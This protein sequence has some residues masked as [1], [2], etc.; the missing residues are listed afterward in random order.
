VRFYDR[1]SYGAAVEVVEAALRVVSAA[2]APL[3]VD[4]LSYRTP[5]GLTTI[6][7]IARDRS[8]VPQSSLHPSLRSTRTR[9]LTRARRDAARSPPA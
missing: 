8:T 7:E 3:H 5:L 1:A 4:L 9:A 6:D 2:H